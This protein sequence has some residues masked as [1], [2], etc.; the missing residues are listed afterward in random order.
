MVEIFHNFINY[1]SLLT[2]TY[3]RL[4][5]DSVFT[6]GSEDRLI[7]LKPKNMPPLSKKIKISIS[8]IY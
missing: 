2:L 8:K 4:T 3:T 6:V 5:E 1:R 7:A